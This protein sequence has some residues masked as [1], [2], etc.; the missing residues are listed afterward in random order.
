[1][2]SLKLLIISIVAVL[3]LTS[4]VSAYDQKV[5]GDYVITSGYDLDLTE[6]QVLAA[7][8]QSSVKSNSYSITE[9]Q[10]RIHIFNP[11][12]NCRRV[13]IDVDWSDKD[14]ELSLGVESPDTIYDPFYDDIDGRTDGRIYVSISKSS[15]GYLPEGDWSNTIRGESV[16]GTE[17]Y[18][19]AVYL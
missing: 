19:Y 2:K 1:M 16:S 14:N 11:G 8:S 6:T 7:D 18:K 15:G 12:Q 5:I 3:L 17:Y 10:S 13:I 4:S 9:G